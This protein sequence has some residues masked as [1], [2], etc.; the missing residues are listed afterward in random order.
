MLCHLD[1]HVCRSVMI[2]AERVFVL[3]QRSTV[4]VETLSILA[5]RSQDISDGMQVPTRD[6]GG[7]VVHAEDIL[8]VSKALEE[9][10]QS[11]FET[12]LNP[13]GKTEVDQW[14]RYLFRTEVGTLSHGVD[15]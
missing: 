15:R 3:E 7:L 9:E 6:E 1:K 5:H 11:F 10:L 2:D 4:E 12:L 13:E 14:K 8:T